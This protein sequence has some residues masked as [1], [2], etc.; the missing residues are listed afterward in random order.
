MAAIGDKEVTEAPMASTTSVQN[1]R[2]MGAL[3]NAGWNAFATICSIAISFLL[4]PVLIRNLG[5]EQYGLLL[6][7]WSV[8]GVLSITNLGVGEATLRYVAHYLGDRDLAGVNRVFGATLSFY[9]VVCGIVTGVFLFAG[10]VVATLLKVPAGEYPLVGSLLRL[11]ALLFSLGMISNAFQSI[12][13]ALQR[14]DISSKVGTG[15]GIIRSI[16]FVVLAISGFGVLHVVL[17]DVLIAFA[18]LCVRVG[19]ARTLLPGVLWVPKASLAGLREIFGYGMFSFLTQI[20][21]S[22]YRESGKLILGNR[23]G[24]SGVAYLGA[25]DSVAYNIYMVVISGIETLMPRF[26]AN[27]DART[28][29]ALVVNATWAALAAAVALF[30][31]LAT[32]MADFLRLWIGPEFAREGAPVGQLLAISFIAPAGFAPIATFF[33]GSG[34]PGYVTIV[35]ASAGSAVLFASVLLVP[36]HGPVGVGY[37]YLLSS[38]GWLSGL[39]W[40]WFRIFGGRSII[41]LTRTVGVPL[42]L[43]GA[44]FTAQVAI[45]GHFG[46]VGWLGLF[47]LGGVFAGLTGLLVIGADLLFGG[48]SLSRRVLER[49]FRSRQIDAICNR[50]RL[51]QAR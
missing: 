23:V 50:I 8:T 17:W 35:M 16:G 24:P 49:A 40:G 42:L 9:V 22:L 39:L 3:T 10:P 19:V 21:L 15:Q 34:K 11:A 7:V 5:T 44:V 32:L 30:I 41:L 12:P 33:R 37:G 6:V 45:R 20:F 26:S 2:P 25:P 38:I 27:R 31:P 4:A 51:W 13:M 46:E 47:V 28:A 36:A 1:A 43:A 14:Y 48:D 29:N 18:T